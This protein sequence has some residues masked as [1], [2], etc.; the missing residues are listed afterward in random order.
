MSFNFSEARDELVV[1]LCEGRT[2]T[3]CT[4]RCNILLSFRTL[5]WQIPWLGVRSFWS[6]HTGSSATRSSHHLFI[7]RHLHQ[8]LFLSRHGIYA[9]GDAFIQLTL[10]ARYLGIYHGIARATLCL[11]YWNVSITH[12]GSNHEGLSDCSDG[13]KHHVVW[14]WVSWS[15]MKIFFWIRPPLYSFSGRA[16]WHETFLLFWL[17]P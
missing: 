14:L 7:S 2:C 5:L 9:S 13:D 11:F 1:L 15:Q 6:T 8:N 10:H 17:G 16:W 4:A 12:E 3:L